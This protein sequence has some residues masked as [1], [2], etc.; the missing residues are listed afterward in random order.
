[1]RIK[2]LCVAS[3]VAMAAGNQALADE[4]L[5]WGGFY[6][7]AAMGATATDF[8]LVDS[9][10]E[11][12]ANIGV[13]AGYDWAFGDFVVG[14]VAEIG[15]VAGERQEAS[16]KDTFAVDAQ[17]FASARLR[18]GYDVGH[19]T[20]VYG[21]GGIAWL[22]IEKEDGFAFLDGSEEETL[23]G[24][25]A[26]GGIEHHLGNG[27]TLGLEYLYADFED[28]SFEGIFSDAQADPK[29]HTVRLTLNIRF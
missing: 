24:W 26:G 17:W 23:T 2:A 9:D 7:G 18:A 5:D 11:T 14:P 22:G 10:W 4:P 3:L 25:T 8:D 6:A 29:S 28:V 20:L 12:G 13:R 15:T 27:A 16:G 19:D 21:T 1:M